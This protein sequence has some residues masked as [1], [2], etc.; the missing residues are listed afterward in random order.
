MGT[1]PLPGGSFIS[2]ASTS[3][4]A[5]WRGQTLSSASTAVRP[6]CFSFGLDQRP[7][8]AAPG[9]D[10]AQTETGSPCTGGVVGETGDGRPWGRTVRPTVVRSVDDFFVVERVRWSPLAVLPGT[11]GALATSLAERPL[12]LDTT[13]SMWRQGVWVATDCSWMFGF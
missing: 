10:L 11:T 3:L 7:R 1:L 8:R 4:E 2:G 12:T 6:R 5:Q 9:F 13:R